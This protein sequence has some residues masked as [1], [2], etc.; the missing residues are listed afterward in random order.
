MKNHQ[1]STRFHNQKFDAMRCKLDCTENLS[2]FEKYPTHPKSPEKCWTREFSDRD[3]N[4]LALVIIVSPVSWIHF[5]FISHAQV[6]FNSRSFHIHFLH[7]SHFQFTF[8]S[9]KANSSF[10]QNSA[11]THS[12]ATHC[13]TLQ[14]TA[15]HCYIKSARHFTKSQHRR[16]AHIPL[17][18]TATHCNTFTLQH[19]AI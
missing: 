6:K 3:P 9:P 5:P 17:Q 15:T 7:S 2:L 4:N 12:T 11:R 1:C 10:H 16:H 14:H 8:I 19:T 13:N 18:H